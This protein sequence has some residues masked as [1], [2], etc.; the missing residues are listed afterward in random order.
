[1]F[2][3]K[4]IP[5]L[6]G[7]SEELKK[8]KPKLRRLYAQAFAVS[9]AQ[10]ADYANP[11]G[12]AQQLHMMPADRAARTEALRNKLTGFKIEG[13]TLPS[14]AL[15]DKYATMLIKGVVKYV[16]W[17]KM[18]SRQQ[19][20]LEEPEIRGLRI[21]PDG[22]LLQDVAPDP[23]T[24]LSGEFLW[25]FGMK[26]RAVACEVSGL[27]SFDLMDSWANEMKTALLREPPMGHRRVSWE[28]LRNSDQALWTYVALK[29]ENGCA[30]K[31]AETE[32]QF[33]IH[34]KAGMIAPVVTTPLQFLPQGTGA[35]STGTLSVPS[36]LT[37][38][39]NLSKLQNRIQNLETQL[40]AGK[41][42]LEQQ[43][44][45]RDVRTRGDK[46]KGKG[47]KHRNRGR[48][49]PD[50]M[51]G[52]PFRHGNDSICFTWNGPSKCPQAGPGGRCPKGLHVC[53]KC[54]KDGKAFAE[55][56]HSLSECPSNR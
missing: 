40:K 56:S 18:T 55:I 38:Q 1:M 29:C 54:S 6:I 12:A 28:Q 52:L 7:G 10:M 44:F 19:E 37:S 34:F 4:V 13:P 35:S 23:T 3:E 14:T 24:N 48:G 21:G 33:S 32:T 8:L 20:V 41:R 39:P 53:P 15:T 5:E 49:I 17:E 22:L 51:E 27:C 16:P 45:E 11:Q 50:Y 42:K 36:P 30:A 46:G 2:E 26:R 31:P 9:Q 25:D 47:G 43:G